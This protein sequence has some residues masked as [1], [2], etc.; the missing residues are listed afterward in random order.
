[1]VSI[2]QGRTFEGKK[3][4]FWRRRWGCFNFTQ[5]EFEVLVGSPDRE[6]QIGVGGT[7][8]I[9]RTSSGLQH[10]LW[11]GPG[12]TGELWVEYNVP[13]RVWSDRRDE[14]GFLLGS[15]FKRW[16]KMQFLKKQGGKEHQP[17]IEL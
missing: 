3:C 10:Q 7:G 4:V 11:P 17:G 15:K 16:W 9:L 14:V 6:V 5:V 2:F 13:A 12:G 8:L 1:M